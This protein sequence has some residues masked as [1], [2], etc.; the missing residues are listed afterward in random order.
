MV[1]LAVGLVASPGRA[2]APPP[3]MR[4]LMDHMARGVRSAQV[5]DWVTYKLDGGGARVH[6]WRLAFVGQEKDR[7][8]RD[9]MWLEIEIGTH[10]AMRAPLGQMKML[11][12]LEGAG[13]QEPI[14]RLIAS[15]GYGKPQEYSSEA[16]E[17]VL[18]EGRE[19][20]DG[21][22]EA[23]PTAAERAL[24]PPVIRSGREARL[25]T[26]A[27]SVTAV[28][29]EVVLRSTVL[30]RMWMSREIP[31]MHL[32]KIEIPGIGQSMEVVEHGVDAQPRIRMPT[33]T[34]VPIRLEYADQAFGKLP[35]LQEEEPH[36]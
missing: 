27:G 18:K 20:P 19:R 29:V 31:I 3:M 2:S 22:P 16:L 13:T 25:M 8:G 10:P 1:A 12:A 4:A 6:Y 36:P 9:A 26:Q 14:T 17:H 21:P 23:P 34:E 7:H 28:P 33:P 35:W 15:A 32:A 5:G 24:P 30:K 11:V